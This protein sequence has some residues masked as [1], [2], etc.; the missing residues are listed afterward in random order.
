MLFR[1]GYSVS[2]HVA[3]LFEH[4]HPELVDFCL[5]NSAPIPSYL[6]E[7]YRA[8]NAGPIQVDRAYTE[9]LG[10]ELITK[11]LANTQ[12]M[13]FARHDT[14]RLAD[15]VMELFDSRCVR[16]PSEEGTRYI[17]ER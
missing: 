11:P 1:S 2:D 8:E 6:V 12:A 17:L 7:K 10:V 16:V 13:D 15:A 14:R 5:A 4:G 9:G 3:A